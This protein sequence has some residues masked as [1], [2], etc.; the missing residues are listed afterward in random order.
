ML[1]SFLEL[2][3]AIFPRNTLHVHTQLSTPAR[4]FNWG[5]WDAGRGGTHPHAFVNTNTHQD[6]LWLGQV[7]CSK[8]AG[9]LPSDLHKVGLER[10][11]SARKT[12]TS[13]WKGLI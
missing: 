5:D 12:H 13:V 7:N 3:Y 8:T 2:L 11:R 10:L 1:V 6:G 4:H 9:Q